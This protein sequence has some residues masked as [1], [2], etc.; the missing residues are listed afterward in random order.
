MAG[1]LQT[2]VTVI[3]V[4]VA[5]VLGLDPYLN[6]ALWLTGMAAIF[7][8]VLQIATSAAVVVHF[9]RARQGLLRR[10]W[11]PAVAAILLSL[12]LIVLLAQ[13]DLLTGAS[14]AVN[15]ALIAVL[16]GVIVLSV[17]WACATAIRKP[18]RLAAVGMRP[19]DDTEETLT[20]KETR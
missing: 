3:A 15:S 7:M 6:V 17:A 19:A 5:A 9:R 4:L 8:I 10:R 20:R 11:A 18:E 1:L 2:V 12:A 16:C 14:S 13:F